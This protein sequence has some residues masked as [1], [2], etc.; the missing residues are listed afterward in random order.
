MSVY[1]PYASSSLYTASF[2][3]TSSHAEAAKYT[4]FTNL[5]TSASA[6]I[7]GSIGPRGSPD[8]CWITTDQYFKLLLT[9][10]LKE[11]CDFPARIYGCC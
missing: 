4:Y 11:Q 1:Y 10:S 6:G 2:A 3:V 9:G 5:V 7:T 8:I